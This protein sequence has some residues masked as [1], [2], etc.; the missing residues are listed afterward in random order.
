MQLCIVGCDFMFSFKYMS[1]AAVA[2]LMPAGAFADELVFRFDNN[3]SYTVVELYA[4]P[5]DVGEWEEDILGRDV[6][7]S[8]ESA[9][10]T[11]ADGR[12]AC[13][14][15]LRVVFEDGDSIEDTTDLCETESYAVTD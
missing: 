6:L 7:E 1:L 2:V 13:E 10:V 11:I 15:D 9:R 12:R 4:S 14:Y 8:G 3:S 5:S